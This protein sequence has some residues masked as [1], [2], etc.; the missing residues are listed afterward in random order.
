MWGRNRQRLD[1]WRYTIYLPDADALA[2]LKQIIS[3]YSELKARWKAILRRLTP[4]TREHVQAAQ[5]EH[6]AGN[7]G[8]VEQ[9][10][11]DNDA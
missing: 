9:P 11:E 8:D 2:E 7:V 1:D 5:S 4:V 6:R 3:E 10:E